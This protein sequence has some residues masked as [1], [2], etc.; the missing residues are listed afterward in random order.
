MRIIIDSNITEIIINAKKNQINEWGISKR[1]LYLMMMALQF[2]VFNG[3]YLFL[4]INFWI[5]LVAFNL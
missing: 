1:V 4:H 5:T 2:V 3:V